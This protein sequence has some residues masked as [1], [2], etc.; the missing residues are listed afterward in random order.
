[1]ILQKGGKGVISAS[2]YISTKNRYAFS[3]EDDDIQRNYLAKSLSN[4]INTMVQKSLCLRIFFS[5]LL[6]RLNSSLL[7]NMF[8]LFQRI[9]LQFC[10]FLKDILFSFSNDS[11]NHFINLSY[12]ASLSLPFANFHLF[13]YLDEWF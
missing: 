8:I 4:P 12:N 3:P 7:R 11:C 9:W 6:R 13:Y 10:S 5:F 1:M 2:L